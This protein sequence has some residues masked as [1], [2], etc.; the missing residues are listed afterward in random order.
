MKIHTI[1]ML[2][3][4]SCITPLVALTPGKRAR[5]MDLIKDV[6]LNRVSEQDL[7]SRATKLGITGSDMNDAK[8]TQLIYLADSKGMHDIFNPALAPKKTLLENTLPATARE[9]MIDAV[10]PHTLFTLQ[11]SPDPASVPL[12]I[13]EFIGRLNNYPYSEAEATALRAKNMRN[14]VTHNP[15][16]GKPAESIMQKIEPIIINIR[17]PQ[18]QW[19]TQS[20]IETYYKLILARIALPASKYKSSLTRN[21]YLLLCKFHRKDTQSELIYVAEMID[22]FEREHRNDVSDERENRFKR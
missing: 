6:E 15:Y 21:I 20:I 1:T 8:V 7:R 3:A 18:A 2:I 13:H 16:A 11:D 12:F 4:C 14:N 22:D 17:N 10:E 19:D 9:I 5:L